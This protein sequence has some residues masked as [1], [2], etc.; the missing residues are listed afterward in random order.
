MKDGFGRVRGA[1]AAVLAVVLGVVLLAGCSVTLHGETVVEEYDFEDVSTIDVELAACELSIVRGAQ[2]GVRVER[3][4]YPEVGVQVDG[5]SLRIM[6]DGGKTKPN[7]ASS[8]KVEITV[9]EDCE[10]E[11]LG[12]DIDAASVTASDAVARGIDIDVEAG[13]VILNGATTDSATLDVEAGSITVSGFAD[14]DNANVSLDVELGSVSFLGSSD[15]SSYSQTGSG[16]TL[17]ATVEA[18]SISVEK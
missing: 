4:N 11:M 9:P 12:I 16:P 13:E 1:L 17:V 18:G 15:G 6:Q 10:L 14:I 8:C 7:E 3:E 5:G 2:G